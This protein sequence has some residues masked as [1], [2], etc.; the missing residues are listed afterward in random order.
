[1][2]KKTSRKEASKRH[3][4]KVFLAGSRV[5]KTLSQVRNSMGSW[6]SLPL[7][8]NTIMKERIWIASSARIFSVFASWL[9]VSTMLPFFVNSNRVA[10]EIV[11]RPCVLTVSTHL[12]LTKMSLFHWRQCTF[13]NCTVMVMVLMHLGHCGRVRSFHGLPAG[14]GSPQR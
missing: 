12:P 6:I 13:S 10:S 9:L 3:R 11:F 8:V 4:F 2:M 1:M 14:S 5:S 7:H